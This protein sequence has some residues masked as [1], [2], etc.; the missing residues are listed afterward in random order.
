MFLPSFSILTSS[1]IWN[2]TYYSK[3]WDCLSLKNGLVNSFILCVC[4]LVAQ[5]CLTLCD[6]MDCSP[7]GC[8]V[9]GILRARILGWVAMPSS[10]GLSRPRDWTRGT[11]IFKQILCDCASGEARLLTRRAATAV[12]ALTKPWYGC[13]GPGPARGFLQS[14]RAGLLL[15]ALSGFSVRW[16]L[17]LQTAVSRPVGF[18][19]CRVQAQEL[20]SKDLGA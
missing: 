3:T 13:A 8:S 17:L 18:S 15:V 6:P 10:R 7:P 9:H 19:S 1:M 14:W 11:Y 20:W 2:T 12:M 4:V 5:S 16:P